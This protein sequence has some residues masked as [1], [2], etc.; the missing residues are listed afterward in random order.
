MKKRQSGS[1]K[2]AQT[3]RQTEISK[4]SSTEMDKR[5]E[6]TSLF[7]LCYVRT[8]VQEQESSNLKSV[9]VRAT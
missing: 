3:E 5:E 6:I 8:Y 9:F 4:L 2:S 7:L 1:K